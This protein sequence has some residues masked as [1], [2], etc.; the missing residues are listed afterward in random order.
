MRTWTKKSTGKRLAVLFAFA[1]G[2]ILVSWGVSSPVAAELIVIQ[3]EATAG[4]ESATY[5]WAVPKAFD[6]AD[7]MDWQMSAPMTLVGGDGPIAIFDMLVLGLDGDPGVSLAFAVTAG[8]LDTNFTITSGTVDF[9]SMTN[10]LAYASAAVTLTDTDSDGASLTGLYAGNKA[11]EAHY[12][13]GPT[14]WAQILDPLSAG[15]D[16]SVAGS[17]RRPASGR[18]VI[19]DSLTSIQSEFNF[20][21]SANDQAS[22]TSRFDVQPA[23]IP[24]PGTWLLVGTGVLGWFGYAFRRR[25][26]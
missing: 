8:V 19:T 15:A 22:G 25:M 5:L 3:I 26:K 24:E 7:H 20:T 1:V 6:D 16:M 11:Y 14:V 21:L 12:N 10:P 4:G 18:E 23:P 17:D 2:A 9:A 13:A